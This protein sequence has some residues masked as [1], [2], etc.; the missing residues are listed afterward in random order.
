MVHAMALAAAAVI[1]TVVL[2]ETLTVAAATATNSGLAVPLGRSPWGIAV[3]VTGA[4]RSSADGEK[5]TQC[6]V[7]VPPAAGEVVGG[8]CGS[9]APHHLHERGNGCSCPCLTGRTPTLARVALIYRLPNVPVES[10]LWSLS[11]CRTRVEVAGFYLI[12][13]SPSQCLLSTN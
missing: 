3:E 2:T 1:T 4:R 7:E 11:R 5:E 12:L 13:S 6:L 9:G 8:V 10:P